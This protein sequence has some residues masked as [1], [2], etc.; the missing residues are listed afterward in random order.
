MLT[1]LGTYEDKCKLTEAA[2]YSDQENIDY[3]YGSSCNKILTTESL[4]PAYIEDSCNTKNLCLYKDISSYE[5]CKPVEADETH[6]EYLNQV[7]NN[8]F[9]IAYTQVDS[10]YASCSDHNISMISSACYS[11]AS[12]VNY[13][14]VSYSAVYPIK[15]VNKNYEEVSQRWKKQTKKSFELNFFSQLFQE[16]TETDNDEQHD[17]SLEFDP[18]MFIKHL[19]PLSEIRT[20]V[21]ALPIRTRSTPG[22]LTLVLDLDETLVHCSL[23]ELKDANFNF[24]VFFQVSRALFRK[25]FFDYITFRSSPSSGLQ[26]HRLC[27]HAT[28]LQGIPRASVKNV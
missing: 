9:N 1:F 19:P 11:N 16:C 27:S 12:T 23:Q 24:P 6:H 15:D 5:L 28:V 26:I 21:P 18:Y 25:K 3:S 4:G 7:D 2:T 13:S 17:V 10:E 22:T 14:T 8:N 20:K